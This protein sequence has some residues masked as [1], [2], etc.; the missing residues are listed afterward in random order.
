MTRW[1]GLA[2]LAGPI[3]LLG[4]VYHDLRTRPSSGRPRFRSLASAGSTPLSASRSSIW[5]DRL[6][7]T[8]SWASV[9]PSISRFPWRSGPQPSPR[10]SDTAGGAPPARCRPPPMPSGTGQPRRSP[11]TSR[12]ADAPLGDHTMEML[13][14]S[15]SREVRWTKVATARP[16]VDTC[17][18]T[19][20]LCWRV[21]AARCSKSFS[22]AVTASTWAIDAAAE[23]S[24]FPKTHSSETDLGG[25][26]R[27]TWRLARSGCAPIPRGWLASHTRQPGR[28]AA[29]G[30]QLRLV[31][32][33][34]L[35]W[36]GRLR[37]VANRGDL[38]LLTAR[39]RA[40][41]PPSAGSGV[42]SSEDRYPPAFSEARGWRASR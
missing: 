19:P 34:P 15:P 18:R 11:P 38:E 22:G 37:G 21:T 6:E 4:F 7:N 36:D 1:I 3:P 33:G 16:D 40:M 28:P 5:R 9:K 10:R 25:H 35:W 41:L 8:P 31:A 23:V 32:A 2:V 26:R 30:R 14:R 27:P 17:R 12:P 39:R 24:E 20:P 29:A 42:V 13:C